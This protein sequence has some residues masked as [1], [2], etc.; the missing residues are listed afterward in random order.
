MHGLWAV[1]AIGAVRSLSALGDAVGENVVGWL[2][3]RTVWMGLCGGEAKVLVATSWFH[4]PRSSVGGD[5]GR[6][7]GRLFRGAWHWFFVCGGAVG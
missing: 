4:V 1:I 7:E 6:T 2:L 3:E 5:R